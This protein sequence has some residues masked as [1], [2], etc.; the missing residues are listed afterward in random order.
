MNKKKLLNYHVSA[1]NKRKRLYLEA[2]SNVIPTP[3][4]YIGKINNKEKITNLQMQQVNTSHKHSAIPIKAPNLSAS[5]FCKLSNY[6][7]V[8]AQLAP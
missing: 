4:A 1:Q 5:G 3:R 6:I 2:R 7:G 8:L